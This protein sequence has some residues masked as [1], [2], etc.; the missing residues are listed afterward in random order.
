VRDDPSIDALA[1]ELERY[2]EAR[3]PVYAATFGPGRPL[4]P[5]VG[6]RVTPV[7]VPKKTDPLDRVTRF[8]DLTTAHP[9]RSSRR[10]RPSS[11]T[12]A[13]AA[14]AAAMPRST[15]LLVRP[16]QR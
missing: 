12:S 7:Q 10:R 9:S 13:A 1:A 8:Y 6:S 2:R 15:C 4:R 14:K 11:A 5:E 16:A 3:I